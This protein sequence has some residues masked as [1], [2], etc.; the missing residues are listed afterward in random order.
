VFGWH[1]AAGEWCAKEVL[2]HLIEAEAPRLRRPHPIIL[3][4]RDPKLE[5]WNQ[6]EVARARRDC[7]QGRWRAPRRASALRGDGVRLVEGAG[8]TDLARG[9]HH[10]K[11]GYLTVGDLLNGGPP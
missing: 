10:P 4:G 7:D 6:D 3:A 2:D 5:T 9:G 8:E 1:P 11:V